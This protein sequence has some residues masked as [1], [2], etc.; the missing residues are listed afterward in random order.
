MRRLEWQG[1]YCP[2]Q[3]NERN[4]TTTNTKKRSGPKKTVNT[5]TQ[6]QS[7]ISPIAHQILHRRDRKMSL[8]ETHN[9]RPLYLISGER[10]RLKRG[11]DQKGWLEIRLECRVREGGE[12]G[13]RQGWKKGAATVWESIFT[14][15]CCSSEFALLVIDNS[16]S[17]CWSCS[18]ISII[19]MI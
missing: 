18:Y 16:L 15:R 12:K 10:K 6:N 19:M 5:A 1:W 11:T 17:T 8:C 7:K 3:R 14:T 4:S 9:R 2:F 13:K